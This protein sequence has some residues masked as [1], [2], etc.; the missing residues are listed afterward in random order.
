MGIGKVLAGLYRKSRALSPVWFPINTSSSPSPHKREDPSPAMSSAERCDFSG[1]ASERIDQNL[2]KLKSNKRYRNNCLRTTSLCGLFLIIILTFLTVFRPF[3]GAD[4]P[5]CRSIYMYPSYA[6]IDGFDTRYTALAK[7]Y[8][9]YLYREQGKDKDPLNNE[10]IR[11]DGIP[12]LFIPGNAGSFRQVRSIAASCANLYFEDRNEIQNPHSRNLDFFAADFNEDFTAFHGRTML[13]QAEYL[14]DAI[15]YI[16]SLYEKTNSSFGPTPTSVIVLGHSMGGIVARILPTLQNHIDGSINSFITLSSPHAAAPVTFDGDIMKIYQRTN[17]YWR[18]QIADKSSF[19]ARNVSLVSIT[20]GILD[21][22]LPADYTAV[23]DLLPLENGFTTYSTTIPGVWTSIDHLAIVWCDQLRTTVSRLLLETVDSRYTDKVRPLKE[24]MSISR[25]LLLSGFEDYVIQDFDV[26]NPEENLKSYNFDYFEGAHIQQQKEQLV[27]S[28]ENIVALANMT[29]FILPNNEPH[30]K[31]SFLASLKGT[32]VLFC[33]KNKIASSAEDGGE[34]SKLECISAL[35]DVV[36]VPASFASTKFAADSSSGSDVSAFNMLTFEEKILS[37]YDFIIVETPDAEKLNENDF[38]ICGLTSMSSTTTINHSPIHIAGMGSE[39]AVSSNML[40]QTFRFTKLWDSLITYSIKASVNPKNGKTLL[41][42]PLIRQWIEDPF[43]SKWHT[44]IALSEININTHNVAPFIP[45]EETHDKSLKL[46]VIMPP[47]ADV[48][49]HIGVNWAMTL[50]M[51]FIRYRLI[52]LSF[53]ISIL[54][55]TMAYQF[56]CYNRTFEF[57]DFQTALD[58]IL[59]NHGLLLAIFVLVL[60]PMVDI[61]VVQKLAYRLDP[62]RLNRPFLL[63][64]QHIHTNFYFLGIRSWFLSGFGLL[65]GLVSVATLFLLSGTFELVEYAIRRFKSSSAKTTSKV[66]VADVKDMP[67][68]KSR[69]VAS[70][71]L[72]IAVSLY[73]PYQLA[74][75]ICL[76]I[77]LGTCV[78]IALGSVPSDSKEY[79]N[80]RNYNFSVFLLLAFVVA[81]NVP[82]IIVFLHNVAIGWETPFRSHHNF[83]AIAP[84]ILLVNSNSTFSMP[85][86]KSNKLNDGGFGVSLLAYLGFFSLI[87]GARNLYWIHHLVNITCAWLL[88]GTKISKLRLRWSRRY[89]S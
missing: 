89:V 24:R 84:I 19:F 50:K 44:N 23:E 18:E 8:H 81:I 40:V 7:K 77:Q 6:R 61:K 1:K 14:N 10:E 21:M 73:I 83:M 28:K 25:K 35:N 26:A 16:L 60:T 63:E 9:L 64:K 85:F 34:G 82:I 66:V 39:V 15:R 62:L 17:D 67:L 87:Y 69:F 75:A 36:N 38:I 33:K 42:E 55:V 53:P 48:K 71:L 80:L 37:L 79:H 68:G 59:H 47:G 12:V 72:I 49:L 27:I 76:I 58:S 4:S 5:Q 78:R 30:L 13:D 41:F 43:E 74:S 2:M 46:T 20:G 3:K 11:L 32:S 45:L 29:M 56:Y 57:M 54:S 51:L 31:F 22:M 52:F 88:Y 86:Y 65:F 70:L